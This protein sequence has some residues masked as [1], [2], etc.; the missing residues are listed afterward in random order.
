MSIRI[1]GLQPTYIFLFNVRWASNWG[2]GV[3]LMAYIK[4]IRQSVLL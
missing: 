3:K 2:V 1:D 4:K